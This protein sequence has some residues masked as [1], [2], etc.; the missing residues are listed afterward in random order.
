V[1]VKSGSV[2]LTFKCDGNEFVLA[3]LESGAILNY[4]SIFFQ[5]AKSMVTA[6]QS[7]RGNLI[8]ISGE[9]LEKI[10]MTNKELNS[11]MLL[12]STKLFKSHRLYLLDYLPSIGS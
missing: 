4:R 6:R 9:Y 5:N 12:F 2:E 3:R 11:K 10:A 7:E 1:I 8:I